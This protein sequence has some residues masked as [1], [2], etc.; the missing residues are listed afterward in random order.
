VV[1][2][3]EPLEHFMHTVHA[4]TGKILIAAIVLHIAA[5]LHHHFIVKDG[6]LRRMLGHPTAVNEKTVG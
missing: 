4:V 5:A 6:T 2:L 3:S 1:D